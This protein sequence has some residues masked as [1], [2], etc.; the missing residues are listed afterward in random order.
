MPTIRKLVVVFSSRTLIVRLF[1]FFFFLCSFV[2]RKTS[3]RSN[4]RKKKWNL[5]VLSSFFK[6]SLTGF[7]HD[8]RSKVNKKRKKKTKKRNKKIIKKKFPGNFADCRERVR[9]FVVLFFSSFLFFM[10]IKSRATYR[11]S[12]DKLYPFVFSANR[13]KFTLFI[14]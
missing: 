10:T 11:F 2:T 12:N 4:E 14:L 8:E 6:F 7:R 3:L 5:F 13:Q 1:I 9:G